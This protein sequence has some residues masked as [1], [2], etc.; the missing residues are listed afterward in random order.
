MDNA[1]PQLVS[2]QIGMGIGSEVDFTPIDW[3]HSD[4]FA[5]KKIVVTILFPCSIG[6]GF[7]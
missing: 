6:A 5:V 4:S 7:A 3:D 1:L 2:L